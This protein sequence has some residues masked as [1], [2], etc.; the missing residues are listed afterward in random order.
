MLVLLYDTGARIQELLNIK[1]SDLH[2]GKSSSVKLHGKGNKT[3]IVPIMESTANRLQ[4]YLK[5][6]HPASNMLSSE[7]LFYVR[8]DGIKKRMT[9]DNARKLIHSYGE[10]ARLIDKN[11]PQ[12]VHPHLFR[13]SRAMH[14]YQNGMDLMLVS[15]WLGHS[16]F[17]TTKIY[18]RA[19]TEMERK[20]IER[21]SGNSNLGEHVNSERYAISD[22]DTL[23]RLM[24]L[25]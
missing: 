8:R 6:F 24:A 18:A 20:A 16:Q 5:A 25:D 10:K 12:S 11:I 2:I 9:E 19:D 22:D 15:Q 14:L 23:R 13:H 17:E 1:L 7:Y 4:I 3:R 21:A